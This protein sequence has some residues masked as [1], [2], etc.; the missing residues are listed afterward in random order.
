MNML[1][2]ISRRIV[3]NPDILKVFYQRNQERHTM[4]AI[5]GS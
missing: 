1:L 5:P 4:G 2:A 3:Y